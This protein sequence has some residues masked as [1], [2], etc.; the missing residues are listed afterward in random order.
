MRIANPARV[1]SD[2]VTV[3]ILNWDEMLTAEDMK[4]I[5]KAHEEREK[6][7]YYKLEDAFE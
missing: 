2:V 1:D 6:G 4:D 7:E 3:K 5:L